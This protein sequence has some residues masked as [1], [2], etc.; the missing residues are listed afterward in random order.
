MSTTRCVFAWLFYIQKHLDSFCS[1]LEA[2]LGLAAEGAVGAAS[3]EVAGAESV[4]FSSTTGCTSTFG[5]SLTGTFVIVGSASLEEGFSCAVVLLMVS[6]LFFLL[7]SIE[8]ATPRWKVFKS[9][10]KLSPWVLAI[11]SSFSLGS[12][13]PSPLANK[14]NR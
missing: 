13:D 1:F 4:F 7:S 6:A 3:V 10:A 8:S 12:R 14:K 9:F 11:S 5:S 2:D